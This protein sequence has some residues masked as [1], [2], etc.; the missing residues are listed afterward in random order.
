MNAA[1][2]PQGPQGIQGETGPT[3][4]TGQGI[5]VLGAYD[6]LEEFLAAH[7]PGS[8]TPGDAYLVGGELFVAD[9]NGNWINTGIVEGPQGPI[10]PTASRKHAPQSDSQ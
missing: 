2:G 10:G 7:P 3:G 1:I 8:G 6:T 4:V 9:E 5:T